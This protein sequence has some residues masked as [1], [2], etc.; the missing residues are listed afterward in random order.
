MIAALVLSLREGL[1]AALI[2]GIVWG[3]LKRLQ[4]MDLAPALW[5]GA[6]AAALASLVIALALGAI[7][8]KMEGKAEEIFEG[9]AMFLACGVLTWMVFWM[10]RQAG[11]IKQT[12]ESSVSQAASGGGQRGLFT[13]AFLSVGKEGFELVLF[14]IAARF[15]SDAWQTLFGALAGLAAAALLGWMLFATTR[16]LSLRAFF[17]VTNVLLI[18]FAAGLAAHGVHEFNEAG[19]IPAV[20]EPVWDTSRL[21]SDSSLVGEIFKALL[22]YNS[23]PSLSEVISYLGYYLV[24]GLALYASMKRSVRIQARAPGN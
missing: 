17:G 20:I 15:A 5:R 13:L 11:T 18:V 16:R 3:A 1:E 8:A 4:R 12:L 6:G 7:G 22:G 19:V 10:R 23:N 21:L 9:V 2:I 14:L 24:I